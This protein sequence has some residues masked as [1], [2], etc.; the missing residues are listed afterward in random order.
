MPLVVLEAMACGL[1]VITTTHGA[2]EIVRDGI[3]GFFVPIRDPE[4]IA[5]RLEQLHRDPALREQ[6][7]RNAREQAMRHTWSAYAQRAADAVLGVATEP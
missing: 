7:G 6:M 5:A 3:D 4:A 2:G 1:P